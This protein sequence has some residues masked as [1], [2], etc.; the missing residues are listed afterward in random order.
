MLLKCNGYSSFSFRTCAANLLGLGQTQPPHHLGTA[1]AHLVEVA[2]YQA[3]PFIQ[4]IKVLKMQADSGVQ[5]LPRSA[6]ASWAVGPHNAWQQRPLA[7]PPSGIQDDTCAVAAVSFASVEQHSR[8]PWHTAMSCRLWGSGCTVLRPRWQPGGLAHHPW[9]LA[10]EC[11]GGAC[12][13]G[14]ESHVFAGRQRTH[15]KPRRSVAHVACPGQ[16]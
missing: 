3:L 5:F 4:K 7:Q 8:V 15:S 13:M 14:L 1:T 9:Q 11:N 2:P 16:L 10:A 6:I 12:T